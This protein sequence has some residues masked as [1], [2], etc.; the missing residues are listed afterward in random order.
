MKLKPLKFIG[1]QIGPFDH[2]ELNWDKESQHTLVVAENGMGKTTIVTAIAACLSLGDQKLFPLTIFQRFAHDKES[3]A[4]FCFQV[5]DEILWS[6]YCPHSESDKEIEQLIDTYVYSSQL[7]LAK[8]ESEIYVDENLSRGD[9]RRLPAKVIH[10]KTWLNFRDSWKPDQRNSLLFAAYGVQRELLRPTIKE[11]GDSE[12]LPMQDSLNPFAP[13][14]SSE[15]FQWVA[16]QHVNYALAFAENNEA[17]AEAYLSGIRRVEQFIGKEL[18]QPISF[19]VKRN[20]FRLE[21]QQNGTTLSVEQLSDGTRSFLGWTLDFLRRASLIN[22][23]NP[24][25]S[26]LAPGLIIVDEIDSHLHPEWQRRVIQVVEQLLPETY[27]IATTHSPFV[28]ASVDDAQIFQIVKGG[29]DEL[30]VKASY[31]ELYGYPADLV[32]QKTFVPS[33]YPPEMEQKLQLLQDLAVKKATR[34]LTQTEEQEHDRLMVE[35][36]QINP[37]LNNLIALS[38]WSA[39]TE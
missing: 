25:D 38:Q 29:N 4:F 30:E 23:K 19:H 13:L 10:S 35:L 15:I 14:R 21:V 6:F 18:G 33:L 5:A 26:A 37:W 11:I 7:T 17:E 36:S 34:K 27:V 3:F 31:D 24:T 20:P 22:W 28:V 32:L 8:K 12:D 39:S 16:N 9:G 1:H 2:I